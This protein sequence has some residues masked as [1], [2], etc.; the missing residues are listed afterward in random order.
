[1][2][3]IKIVIW[4]AKTWELGRVGGNLESIMSNLFTDEKTEPQQAKIAL[5]RPGVRF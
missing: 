4:F 1:M 2:L 5:Y 3:V